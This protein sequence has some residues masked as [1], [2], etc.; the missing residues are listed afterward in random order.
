M[1]SFFNKFLSG[2][3]ARSVKAIKNIISSFAI[4]GVSMVINI[5]LVPLT[6]HYLSPT[7]YGLWLTIGSIM[8]WVNFFDIGLGH[9]LRNKLAESFAKDDMKK[10]QSY[11]STAYVSIAALSMVVFLIF[12][13]ANHFINWYELL[14]IPS[15]IDED[16]HAITLLVFL[17]F[18]IQ[19]ILQLINS[20][21]LA[22]QQPARV[23]F[24]AMLGNILI[25]VG[26]LLLKQFG[27]GSLY[28]VALLFSTMP[29]LVLLVINLFYY[30]T[31]FRAYY[32]KFSAID[33]KA[34]G[35][36]LN[37]GVKF[38]IIQVTILVFYE[39][40]NFL[41]SRYFG[42]GMVPPYTVAFRYFGILTMAFSI[43]MSPFWSAYTEA[44]TKRDFA[45]ITK[46][47]RQLLRIWLLM[48]VGAVVMLIFSKQMYFLW[49]KDEV[50]VDFDI[51]LFMMIFVVVTSFGNIF[52]MLL[53]GI[54]DIRLQMIVN[55]I[56]MAAFF[57]VSYLFAVM[58]GMGVA[59]IILATIICSFY[60]PVIAPWQ[61]RRILRNAEAMQ[62]E[63]Q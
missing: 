20:I 58:W 18:C 24:N 27:D 34:L 33:F 13:I 41:I 49:V 61:V 40:S 23:S 5:L 8:G 28:Q 62:S 2:T 47:I 54:G 1:L 31:S 48:V 38:F 3:H 32:P 60:G 51:S 43:I 45:W 4:K 30:R 50:T 11:V 19:F 7:K 14:N 39:M 25:L 6:I 53:N 37:L 55:L 9:G 63:K 16:M 35:D 57:P 22:N 12:S 17:M 36:V 59:G 15:D 10:A 42:P 21:F 56:G 44:Y 29:V 26:V 46:S 52:I